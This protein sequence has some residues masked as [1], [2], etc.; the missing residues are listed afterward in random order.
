MQTLRVVFLVVLMV[1][2]LASCA[3]ST[4]NPGDKVGSFLITTGKIDEVTFMYELDSSNAVSYETEF[5]IP[6][7]TKLVCTY[8]IF[9]PN[10]NLDVAWSKQTYT[11]EINGRPV[12]LPSFGTIDQEHPVV[13]TMRFYNVVIEAD[14]PGKITVR[15]AGNTGTT[16]FDDTFTLIFLPPE[17]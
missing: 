10:E 4:I 11:L 16:D 2:G 14:K 8:G 9:N 6:W 12:N 3:K 7:G 15:N 5:E 17:E 1:F 13:G